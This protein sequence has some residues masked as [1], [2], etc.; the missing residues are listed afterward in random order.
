MRL[1]VNEVEA[2]QISVCQDAGDAWERLHNVYP[3]LSVLFTLGSTG[4]RAYSVT[5][6]NIE[7]VQQKA[8]HVDAVDTTGAGDTYTG[9]F[10]GGLMQEL[11]LQECMKR[12]SMAAALS[13][14]KPGAAASIPTI[15]DVTSALTTQ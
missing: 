7:M 5:N 9:F 11:P 3:G 6:G 1:C 8:F 2:E 10:I 12:A 14:M 4:S 15:G 13:V